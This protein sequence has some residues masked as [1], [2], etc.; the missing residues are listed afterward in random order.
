MLSLQI[1]CRTVPY[2]N[3]SAN[4]A[5]RMNVGDIINY[6]RQGI[7]IVAF[8]EKRSHRK[9][10]LVLSTGTAAGMTE[11]R[12]GAGRDKLKPGTAAGMTE[13]YTGA[14][15][16]KLKPDTAA[17]MTEV[18]TGAGC[19]KLKSGTAAGITE[20]RTGAGRDKLNPNCNIVLYEYMGVLI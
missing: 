1:V 11:V 8:R 3:M 20:V 10:V 13:V 15:R 17:G 18:Y 19:D 9:P 12:T 7:L 2:A 6:R 16:D 14:G 5:T 4:N